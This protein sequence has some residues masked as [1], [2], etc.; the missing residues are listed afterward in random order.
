[1]RSLKKVFQSSGPAV[2]EAP[3]EML[4][5]AIAD[6]ET[7]R[8]S[9]GVKKEDGVVVVVVVVEE[10]EEGLLPLHKEGR[11]RDACRALE[12]PC[13]LGKSGCEIRSPDANVAPDD[14]DTHTR[15]RPGVRII[16][17]KLYYKPWSSTR[18]GRLKSEAR[19]RLL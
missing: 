6:V 18:T 12:E 9:E 7:Y 4:S 14:L 8:Q 10:E 3:E 17:D 11:D 5:E 16:L 19:S 1:M 13:R 15:P 2:A